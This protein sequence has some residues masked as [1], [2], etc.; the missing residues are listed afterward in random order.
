MHDDMVQPDDL[1]PIRYRSLLLREIERLS[2]ERRRLL[3]RL[4]EGT[5][6]ESPAL[7]LRLVEV[8]K[9]L[10]E[11]WNERRR[12]LGAVVGAPDTE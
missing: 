2:D 10:T 12:E 5:R 9:N 7:R 8:N 3:R 1:A 4:A 11:L 6:T